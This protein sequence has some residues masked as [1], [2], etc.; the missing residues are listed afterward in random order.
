MGVAEE[1]LEFSRNAKLFQ[2]KGIAVAVSNE[3]AIVIANGKE[4]TCR[5]F[6]GKPY[7]PEA[8]NV[9]KTAG[10]FLMFTPWLNYLLSYLW[11]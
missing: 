4:E 11:E 9:G 7:C 8:Y 6:K 1:L 5:Y 3:K 10:G 2:D